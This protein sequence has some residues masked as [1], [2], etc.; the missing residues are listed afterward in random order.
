MNAYEQ[1][2]LM[3]LKRWQRGISEE[4]S[5]ISGL[6]NG[7]QQGINRLVPE[8]VHRIVTEAV[9]DMTKAVLLGSEFTSSCILTNASLQERERLLQE[10]INYYTRAGVVSG[11]GT[12]AGGLLLGLADFP[13]LL[14]IKMKFLF[15]AATIYGF[16]VSDY[17]ERLYI[18]HVFQLAFSNP[19]R[20]TEV[21]R[22]MLDWDR[23]IQG[24]PND[25]DQFD[26][27]TFQQQYRDYIDLAK[28]M[29]LV[30]GI[31]AVVGAYANYQ[32]IGKLAETAKNAYRMRLLEREGPSSDAR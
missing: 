17:R 22:T 13:I 4:A 32:L 27:R 24:L 15:D 6:A 29:Q 11:A 30:P 26:W 1:N 25:M 14:G 3:E 9:K 28:L 21:Y 18:L 10:K 8:K 20:R 5:G 23:Y 19:R 2:A 12:G 31:G 16:N 7:I